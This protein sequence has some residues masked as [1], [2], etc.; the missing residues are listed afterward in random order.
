LDFK[1]ENGNLICIV[2]DNGIGRQKFDET[3]NQNGHISVGISLIYQRLKL[4]S[5]LYNGNYFFEYIDLK[6]SFTG[7]TGTKV[8]L[9][10]P[11]FD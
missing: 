4:M 8:I 10:L 5:E 1:I 7:K 6:D 11:V 9:K 2:K 3:K